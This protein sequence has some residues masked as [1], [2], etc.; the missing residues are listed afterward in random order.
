MM[1]TW[2][3]WGGAYNVVR[4]DVVRSITNISNHSHLHTMRSSLCAA[5]TSSR[6]VHDYLQTHRIYIQVIGCN[7]HVSPRPLL[8]SM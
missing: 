2:H 5:T 4:V 1:K 7:V 8:T 6:S 3:G